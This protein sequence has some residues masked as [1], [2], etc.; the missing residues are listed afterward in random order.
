MASKALVITIKAIDQIS[1]PVRRTMA[2]IGQL[3]RKAIDTSA[4]VLRSMGGLAKSLLN[5]RNLLAGLAVAFA[6]RAL[7]RSIT[8]VASALD[9]TAKS[10]RS[11]GI[12]VEEYSRLEFAAERSGIAVGQLSKAIITAQRATAQFVRGEGGAA[13]RAFKDLDVQL[14]DANG[15]VKQ[16]TELLEA[17][18]V[19]IGKI[20]DEAV[21]TQKL[22]DI[23]GRTGAQFKNIGNDL[24]NLQRDADKYGRVTESQTAVAEAFQDA[25]TNQARAWT[26]FRASVLEAIGPGLTI[27]INKAAEQTA[28]FGKMVGDLLLTVR[29]AF[30]DGQLAA[31]AK[32]ALLQVFDNIMDMGRVLI[33]SAAMFAATKSAIDGMGE[34]IKT[35]LGRELTVGFSGAIIALDDNLNKLGK[36]RN[37]VI[38]PVFSLAVAEA[39]KA[40]IELTREAMSSGATIGD[41]A[42]TVAARVS[43]VMPAVN[44]EIV[45]MRM[46]LLELAPQF[47]KTGELVRSVADAMRL[48]GVETKGAGDEAEKVKF[49]FAD[50]WPNIWLGIQNTAKS[51]EPLALQFQQLGRDVYASLGNQITA[52]LTAFATGTAKAKEAFRNMTQ[53]ILNDIAQLTIRMAVLNALSGIFAPKTIP[54]AELSGTPAGGFQSVGTGF[55]TAFARSGGL[56]RPGGH[57]RRFAGGGMV[58]GPNINR[59]MV[60]ALLA[61]GEFVMSRR[62]VR[63]AGTERLHA[64]NR[65]EGGGGFT[66]NYSPTFHLNGGATKA[67]S[68]RISSDL[69]GALADACRRHPGARDQLAASLGLR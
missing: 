36:A 25:L 63:A 54:A 58:P 22:Y 47:D 16:G 12:A 45:R 66:F 21:K 18:L 68:Q 42:G 24:A 39:R 17:I 15:R 5:V 46:R 6:A 65:G 48:L 51:I 57:V 60:P 8:G 38:N 59:D 2:S 56:I 35:D 44:D 28:R 14:T 33:D 13:A 9:Q 19:P 69:I 61:P 31:Q 11:L 37:V 53:G 3:G 30:G 34:F 1:A 4:R 49:K 62:G 27:V 29:A 67:D 41:V 26:F 32:V 43:E 64:M 40:A 23:F 7:I 10:A 52:G 20:Q 50:I 55:T